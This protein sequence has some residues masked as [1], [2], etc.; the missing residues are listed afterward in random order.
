MPR[1]DFVCLTRGCSL[2]DSESDFE[3]PEHKVGRSN[4]PGRA[5]FPMKTILSE[6]SPD[7]PRLVLPWFYLFAVLPG[8]GIRLDRR[9]RNS[10]G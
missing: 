4:R 1:Q 2:V 6:R 7:S 3:S 5:I 10:T 9:A 8:P